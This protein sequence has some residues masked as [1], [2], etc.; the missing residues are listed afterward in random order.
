M[1]CVAHPLIELTLDHRVLLA[2]VRL[3]GRRRER[4]DLPAGGA[5]GR[6]R[7]GQ[8][9]PLRRRR[10]RRAGAGRRAHPAR[11]LGHLMEPVR[12]VVVPGIRRLHPASRQRRRA[13]RQRHRAAGLDLARLVGRGSHE[14]LDGRRCRGL[15]LA[16]GSGSLGGGLRLGGRQGTAFG[17]GSVR[18]L[19]GGLHRSRSTPRRARCDKWGVKCG[20][21]AVD[22]AYCYQNDPTLNYRSSRSRLVRLAARSP[23]NHGDVQTI[24]AR[25]AALAHHRARPPRHAGPTGQP[26]HASRR[27]WPRHGRFTLSR[28]GGQHCLLHGGCVGHRPGSVADRDDAD[29]DRPTHAAAA[30]CGP[31]ARGNTQ[32]PR[33]Q[34]LPAAG[35]RLTTQCT[36]A[37]F[38][39]DGTK[40]HRTESQAPLSLQEQITSLRKVRQ[41][42]L[43][44]LYLASGA[45]KYES[46]EVGLKYMAD[47]KKEVL[48]ERAQVAALG[49][50]L[51]IDCVALSK[52][53]PSP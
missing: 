40:A 38:M 30:G 39:T 49:T 37:A 31:A 21:F 27:P 2:V 53:E 48:D 8:R 9:R 41:S 20:R 34:E 7:R 23:P 13:G 12:G 51:G 24:A 50:L 16:I 45:T 18:R 25:P 15:S 46:Q 32:A 22:A 36:H 52:V 47:V 3:A 19:L 43:T 44:F 1:P 35:K 4:G 6:R 26:A 11:L 5:A 33:G 14:L 17:R 42:S 28:S 10:R 29:A